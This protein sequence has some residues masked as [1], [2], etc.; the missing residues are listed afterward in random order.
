MT[1]HT[2]GGAPRAPRRR[3]AETAAPG[4][5][6]RRHRRAR[7]SSPVLSGPSLRALVVGLLAPLFV[8]ALGVVPSSAVIG[9]PTPAT[10]VAAATDRPITAP[11]RQDATLPDDGT[12]DRLDLSGIDDP[13]HR[14]PRGTI[15]VVAT[16]HNG[17]AETISSPRATL[18]VSWRL[19]GT[20]TALAAWA[21]APTSQ[22]PAEAMAT[23]VLAPIAPG[24]DAIVTFA[25][26][27]DDF[28]LE[29][30]STWGPARSR[31]PSP[32]GQRGSTSCAPS[33]C[34]RTPRRPSRSV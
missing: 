12:R 11:A 10:S 29:P 24:E 18:G 2:T 17:T 16:I 1:F 3:R 25:L 4:S 22:R 32:K 33:S 13:E 34:G 7:E 19:L 9:A 5:T 30:G 26:D 28:N 15:T 8:L 23:E 14:R 6:S 27:T 21:D 31:S 20:R